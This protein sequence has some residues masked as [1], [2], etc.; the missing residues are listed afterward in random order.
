MSSCACDRS[1]GKPPVELLVAVEAGLR[2]TAQD[3]FAMGTRA[4]ESKERYHQIDF[5]RKRESYNGACRMALECGNY[6]KYVS[7]RWSDYVMRA[8]LHKTFLAR[9]WKFTNGESADLDS[10]FKN[11]FGDTSQN[12]YPTTTSQ[13]RDVSKSGETEARRVWDSDEEEWKDVE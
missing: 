13:K 6:L 3:K 2:L 9:H 7:Y 11:N 1:T 12:L 4:Y 8:R 10:Y 5:W